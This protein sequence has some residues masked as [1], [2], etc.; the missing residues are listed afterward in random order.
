MADKRS[1]AIRINWCFAC[2]ALFDNAA[3]LSFVAASMRYHAADS[4][5]KVER[6]VIELGQSF[7][8]V[9]EAIRQALSCDGAVRIACDSLHHC[10]WQ[11]CSAATPA[12]QAE[13]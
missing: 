8:P 9:A 2:A 6:D 1:H 12:A 11:A 10:H 3:V 7:S 5:R 4:M 13:S